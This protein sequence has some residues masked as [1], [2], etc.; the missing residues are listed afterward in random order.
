MN[1]EVTLYGKNSIVQSERWQFLHEVMVAV[2]FLSSFLFRDSNIRNVISNVTC[3]SVT[4]KVSKLTKNAMSV[5]IS[6]IVMRRSLP[7]PKASGVNF[8]K[9]PP[10]TCFTL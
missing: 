10:D 5:R 8:K 1:K 6:T 7:S 9:R 2:F 4:I 3:T